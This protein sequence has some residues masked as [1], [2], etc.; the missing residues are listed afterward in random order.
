MIKLK[1]IIYV[2]TL[3]VMAIFPD[4]LIATEI[5]AFSSEEI[6][7]I[8]QLDDIVF[9]KEKNKGTK[10]GWGRR[11]SGKL[12]GTLNGK[13]I[14]SET[15]AYDGKWGY[16]F[17]ITRELPNTAWI[18]Y[19]Y[20]V[21]KHDKGTGMQAFDA[22]AYANKGTLEFDIRGRIKNEELGMRLW[23]SL[24]R[25]YKPKII[26]LTPYLQDTEKWQHVSIPIK[27]FDLSS[28]G[29]LV[30]TNQLALVNEG[31]A[32]RITF[33][34]DNI[35]LKSNGSLDPERP[36]VRL[37]HAGY[38]P[39]QKKV[40]FVGG[41]RLG[42]AEGT[43][44]RVY[45]L[46][47]NGKK[48]DKPVFTGKLRLRTPFED[49]LYGEFLYEA[50]F[51]SLKKQ[52]R[53]ILDIPGI[54]TS[55][56]F[57]VHDA[58]YDYL[59]Y[60]FARVFMFQRNGCSLP[61]KNAFEWN[62]GK[63]YSDP[64]P[65]KNKPD[66]KRVVSHGWF[67]AGDSRLFPQYNRFMWLSFAY[68]VSKD[69][70]FDGQLNI[71][72]SNN[73]IPDLLDELRYQVEYLREMQLDNGGCL[74]LL[75]T[76]NRK[77]L[78]GNP[79]KGG[80]CGYENDPDPREIID[81]YKIYYKDGKTVDN[82]YGAAYYDTGMSCGSFAMMARLLQPYDAKGSDVYRKA[83]LKAWNFLE[84]YG[85]KTKFAPPDKWYK[86]FHKW[87]PKR[88]DSKLF[89][90]V[91]LWRL[92]GKKKY[93]DQIEKLYKMKSNWNPPGPDGD[94]EMLA[95]VSYLLAENPAPQIRTFY[96]SR[97]KSKF[98]ELEK[99]AASDSYG[100]AAYHH[101][102]YHGLSYTGHE[103]GWL[104]LAWKITG[105]NKYKRLAEDHL[106]YLLGR[107]IYRMCAV[108]GIAPDSVGDMFHMIE[109][110]PKRKCS[111]PGYVPMGM[112]M[113]FSPHLS[114]FKAR[115]YRDTRHH[116]F[117]NEPCVGANYGPAMAAMILMNGKKHE[118]LISDGALPGSK[119]VR[120]GL[121]FAPIEK[122]IPW[123]TVNGE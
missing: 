49:K 65:L 109:W 13:E 47:K 120:P 117:M 74:A 34:L 79:I 101:G 71:P 14:V 38:V 81:Y 87:D 27:D 100:T 98:E 41:S 119:S 68:E 15:G 46:E 106:H 86:R 45:S 95:M 93:H 8:I 114:K 33:D 4:Y 94:G 113:F 51:S 92:T 103:A 10:I 43:E 22:Y 56:P 48:S 97:A 62:R 70:H 3:G 84:K 55:V 77:G 36:P 2:F 78:R 69:K 76:A 21:W 28:R 53:Y 96:L 5:T 90:A 18:Y 123:G 16:H 82:P 32:G 104:A 115:R 88:D 111:P 80:N 35:I 40:A 54:G 102:W 75:M 60:H 42:N 26:P 67:D 57:Y 11:I 122:H 72:E 52:G 29:H 83:A 58:I 85:H 99:T 17:D 112:V 50:D 20:P 23:C 89:A 63:I 19:F 108:S 1:K 61:A 12:A 73:G 31:K 105:D 121:P 6:K 116:W 25:D 39:D 91:E 37:N 9:F 44:F 7:N 107:N 24:N 66:Q 30:L 59:F 110:T 118:D 64:T